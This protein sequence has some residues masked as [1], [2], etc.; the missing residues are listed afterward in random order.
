MLL[1]YT[2]EL[3]STCRVMGDIQYKEGESCRI[4]KKCLINIL[5]YTGEAG[6]LLCTKEKLTLERTTKSSHSDERK[7]SQ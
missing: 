3:N 1:L 4:K 7:D 5:E 2:A 6:A